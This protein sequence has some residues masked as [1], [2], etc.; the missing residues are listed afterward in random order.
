MTS[1]VFHTNVYKMIPKFEYECDQTLLK[2]EIKQISAITLFSQKCQYIESCN[3]YKQIY[4]GLFSLTGHNQHM[5]RSPHELFSLF[6]ADRTQQKQHTS[7]YM[8]L[9]LDGRISVSTKQGLVH[10]DI[11]QQLHF[12]FLTFKSKKKDNSF[13]F[14]ANF[15]DFLQLDFLANE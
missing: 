4:F 3:F 12:L 1:S 8:S 7:C 2:L 13:L 6:A 5:L 15:V 14:R 11:Q 10:N 9:N